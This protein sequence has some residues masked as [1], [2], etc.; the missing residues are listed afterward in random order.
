[1]L[2]RLSEFFY[3]LL[4]TAHYSSDQVVLLRFGDFDVDEI[5]RLRTTAFGRVVDEHAAVYVGRLGLR[6]PLPEK[7]CL[8]GRAL[9]E[10][11]HRLTDARRVL[12]LRDARLRFHQARTPLT[13]PLRVNFV[14][15]VE[16]GR[17]LLVRVR[18][19][20]DAVEPDVADEGHQL[21]EVL[22]R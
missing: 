16:S 21:V 6:A 5:P 19:D 17:A 18:E 4:L 3:C 7:V 8:T 10:H 11:A 9:E 13:R 20:T 15:Q 14:R 12:P 1:M 2:M 22:F